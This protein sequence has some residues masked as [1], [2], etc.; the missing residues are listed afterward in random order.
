M[1]RY[2]FFWF[3]SPSSVYMRFKRTFR[4]SSENYL[5][6]SY[7]IKLKMQLIR[8]VCFL[9]NYQFIKFYIFNSILILLEIR[10]EPIRIEYGWKNNMSAT[11]STITHR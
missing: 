7:E 10:E 8:K 6:F 3:G 5:P 9:D 4:V 2:V 11:T 1:K